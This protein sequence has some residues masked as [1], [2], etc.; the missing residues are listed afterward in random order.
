VVRVRA[1]ADGHRYSPW[2]AALELQAGTPVVATAEVAL[3]GQQVRVRLLDAKGRAVAGA[4]PKLAVRDGA[5][6]QLEVQDGVWFAQWTPPANGEDVLSVDER[7]FHLDA[8]LRAPVD[9]F[10]SVTVRAGG[11]FSGGAVASPSFGLGVTGRLPFL[12]RRPGLELR[13][14]G[15]GAGASAEVGGAR[16]DAQAVL[17]P[18][19]LMVAWHQNVSA[20]Q[21]KGGVGPALQL[22]WVQVGGERGF[23]ALPGVDVAVGLSRRVGPGRLEAEVS[24][25]YARLD[26]PLAR[27]NAGGVGVRVGYAFDFLSEVH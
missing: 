19:S 24:F 3:V 13:V 15:F 20:F 2:T 17:V 14:G 18:L 11:I 4:A 27:L 12:Q 25:V 16:L 22:A 10:F 7:A 9:P 1:V 8:P 21:L 26:S 5:L 6:A 23:S